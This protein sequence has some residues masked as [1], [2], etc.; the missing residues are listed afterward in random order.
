MARGEQ[1]PQDFFDT[2]WQTSERAKKSFAKNQKDMLDV[3]KSIQSFLKKNSNKADESSKSLASISEDN[4]K[5][6]EEAYKNMV[7]EIGKLSK[8]IETKLFGKGIFPDWAKNLMNKMVSTTAK[9]SDVQR[10]LADYGIEEKTL[11]KLRDKKGKEIGHA[12][13]LEKIKARITE[14]AAKGNIYEASSVKAYYKGSKRLSA[15]KI[16]AVM[17]EIQESSKNI[18]EY[19]KAQSA[20]MSAQEDDKKRLRAEKEAEEAE[21]DKQHSQLIKVLQ[22]I[23]IAVK[24]NADKNIL[25]ALDGI[26]KGFNKGDS[27][28]NTIANGVGAK[29]WT[30]ASSILAKNIPFLAK[31]VIPI[32][33]TAVAGGLLGYFAGNKIIDWWESYE[34]RQNKERRFYDKAILAISNK[35]RREELEKIFKERESGLRSEAS[36]EAA[37]RQTNLLFNRRDALLK[38][39]FEDASARKEILKRAG[40]T[41]TPGRKSLWGFGPRLKPGEM[42]RLEDIRKVQKL[43]WDKVQNILEIAKDVYGRKA[44]SAG[45][46]SSTG[47]IMGGYG[48]YGYVSSELGRKESLRNLKEI[49]EF[50]KVA[51]AQYKKAKTTLSNIEATK[52][53]N[54]LRSNLKESEI[55]GSPTQNL[56]KQISALVQQLQTNKDFK[57]TKDMITVLQNI[58]RFM[59][60]NQVV[61]VELTKGINALTEQTP[62]SKRPADRL[63]VPS[64]AQKPK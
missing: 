45:T 23:G 29:G 38:Q 20:Q 15:G 47:Q 14:E 36:A 26:K 56:T 6:G 55:K 3:L 57:V 61:S 21:D 10:T 18:S 27:L 49:E 44:S 17:D 4:L 19:T 11:Y 9:V 62:K 39:I 51:G 60:Q 35:Q 5:A 8:G 52:V 31:G 28:L 54:T 53:I 13:S 37:E 59:E 50:Q 58:T 2:H 64:P 24:A 42:A 12:M 34:A 33:I 48:G 1:S 46:G 30:L 32:T 7:E 41:A 63:N 25:E 22:S 43:P 40:M 16:Q